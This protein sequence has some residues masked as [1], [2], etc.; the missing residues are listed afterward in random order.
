MFLIAQ[1]VVALVASVVL[2]VI[3]PSHATPQFATGSVEAI[4]PSPGGVFVGG[5]DLGPGAVK[6]VNNRIVWSIPGN[7]VWS[8]LKVRGGVLVGSAHGVSKYAPPSRRPRWQV[9]L[10]GTVSSLEHISGS[11]LVVAAGR[12]PG[13]LRVIN[14]RTGTVA[15]K[16][17]LPR[18]SGQCCTN[19][20]PTRIYR[21]DMQPRGHRYIAVGE[22]AKVAGQSRSQAVM[23]RFSPTGARLVRWD[24]PA[25]HTQ[26]AKRQPSYINDAEWSHDGRRIA[27]ASGGGRRLGVCDSVTTVNGRATG[28]NIQPNAISR[29]CTDTLQSV[30]WAPD[31]R[32]IFAAGHQKCAELRPGS[33]IFRPRYGLEALRAANL[34]L[35][36]WRSDKCRAVGSRELTWRAGLWV[37]YDCSFWGNEQGEHMHRSRLAFLPRRR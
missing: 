26:C 36:Q 9:P 22:F 34:H 25:L 21:A 37:G 32:T 19:S 35:R 14:V 17:T 5:T 7:N 16:Y 12:F 24:M 28:L 4:E 3:T 30:E 2:P 1:M 27:F 15:K 20:G 33:L 13:S 29:T 8:L 6:I 18:L 11:R 31:D 10:K 23:L